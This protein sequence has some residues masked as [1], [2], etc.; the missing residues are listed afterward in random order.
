MAPL[1]VRVLTLITGG[2]AT[3]FLANIPTIVLPE[4][5]YYLGIKE[6]ID[7]KPEQVPFGVSPEKFAREVLYQVEKNRTGKY[8][9]GG[10]VG[11]ARL[12]LWLL[13]EWLLVSPQNNQEVGEFEGY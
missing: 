7:K 10:M 5:S 1:G 8:W 3:N 9:I 4:N 6:I 13:P 11:F 2:V 12:A